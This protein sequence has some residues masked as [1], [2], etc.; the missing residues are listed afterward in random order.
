ME[1]TVSTPTEVKN[2]KNKKTL[3]EKLQKLAMDPASTKNIVSDETNIPTVSNTNPPQDSFVVL[4]ES[5]T[6]FSTS[7]RKTEHKGTQVNHNLDTAQE[8]SRKKLS[9]HE[10]ELQRHGPQDHYRHKNGSNYTILEDKVM[11]SPDTRYHDYFHES[12]NEKHIGKQRTLPKIKRSFD[13]TN[14]E[15]WIKSMEQSFLAHKLQTNIEKYECAINNIHINEL[16][17]LCSF[18]QQKELTW[19]NLKTAIRAIYPEKSIAERINEVMYDLPMKTSPRQL[20]YDI[21]ELLV[22]PINQLDQNYQELIKSLYIQKLPQSLQTIMISQPETTSLED[23]AKLAE[24]VY[25]Q[26]KTKK[27]SNIKEDPPCDM[28]KNEQMEKLIN[29]TNRILSQTLVAVKQQGESL[30][31]TKTNLKKDLALLN[32][33]LKSKEKPETSDGKDLVGFTQMQYRRPGTPFPRNFS[34]QPRKQYNFYRKPY[35]NRNFFQNNHQPYWQRPNYNNFFH[36]RRGQANRGFRPPRYPSQY[37]NSV[38][39][40]YRTPEF[41]HSSQNGGNNKQNPFLEDTSLKQNANY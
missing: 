24:R 8:N 30:E 1:N 14:S 23:L 32:T 41:T 6:D 29:N 34:Y 25:I 4:D 36:N 7:S 3:I 37:H 5:L 28:P 20:M 10:T 26:Q 18:L 33:K 22:L 15:T 38:I 13:K 35:G 39:N 16:S 19:D 40:G 2:E 17:K 12:V 27:T 21:L 11:V 31:D 9:F